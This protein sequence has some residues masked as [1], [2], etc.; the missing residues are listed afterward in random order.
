[1]TLSKDIKTKRFEVYSHIGRCVPG[2]PSEL[3][4]S[5]RTLESFQ[6]VHDSPNL[7]TFLRALGVGHDGTVDPC[8]EQGCIELY[9]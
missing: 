7:R 6:V 1:M 5:P 4:Q 2:Y 9:R 8:V 3:L